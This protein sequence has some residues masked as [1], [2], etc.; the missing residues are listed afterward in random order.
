MV[1][2]GTLRSLLGEFDRGGFLDVISTSCSCYRKCSGCSYS[3]WQ[4]VEIEQVTALKIEEKWVK[5][6]DPRALL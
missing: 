2:T 4:K 3:V 1:G 6:N 5:E